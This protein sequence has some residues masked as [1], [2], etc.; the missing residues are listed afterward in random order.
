MILL[1]N[2]GCEGKDVDYYRYITWQVIDTP[3]IL[4]H[5]LDERN[6]IEMQSIT[7][8]AHLQAAILFVLDISEQCGYTIKQQVTIR[9][10]LFFNNYLHN[11]QVSLFHSIKPLF[12]GKPIIVAINKIDVTRPEQVEAEDKALIDAL[13]DIGKGGMTGVKVVPMSTLTEEGVTSV[14]H[15]VCTHFY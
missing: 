10:S 11:L 15:E 3:G 6:T 2:T 1:L 13:A 8:M 9:S 12:V 7:A 5:P 4:D 14:L